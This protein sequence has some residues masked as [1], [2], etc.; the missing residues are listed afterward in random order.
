H[1]VRRKDG[2]LDLDVYTQDAW[3]L[4]INLSAG[5]EGGQTFYSYGV[6]EDNVLGS[7]KTVAASHFQNGPIRG[8]SVGYDDPRV[9]GTRFHF[10]PEYAKTNQGDQIATAMYRPF[11]AL[12]TPY[13]IG[14]SWNRKVGE[15]TLYNNADTLNQFL[16]KTHQVTG[17]FGSRLE[18]DRFFVQR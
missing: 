15:T 3:T 16:Q 17:T 5:T 4:N 8:T 14:A 9:L 13:A 2:K 6:S 18:P 1:P 7:G 10:T 12:E 11:F